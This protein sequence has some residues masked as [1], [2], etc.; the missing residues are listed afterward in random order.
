MVALGRRPSIRQALTF[1]GDHLGGEA[2]G[3]AGGITLDRQL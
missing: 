1:D 2:R 3:V